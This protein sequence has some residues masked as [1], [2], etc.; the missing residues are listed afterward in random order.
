M[1]FVDEVTDTVEYYSNLRKHIEMKQHKHTLCMRETL[2]N[3]KKNMDKIK[4]LILLL[5]H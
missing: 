4:R 5:T 2:R 3:Y 1:L